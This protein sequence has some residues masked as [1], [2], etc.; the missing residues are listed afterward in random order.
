MIEI[1]LDFQKIKTDYDIYKLLY[2]KLFNIELPINLNNDKRVVWD[3]FRDDFHNILYKEWGEYNEVDWE[4]YEDYLKDKNQDS[5]YGIKNKQGVRDDMQLVF[6]NFRK[7]YIEYL[8][9]AYPF[10]EMIFE[11]IE[12]VNSDEWRVDG[13]M[14]Q[15]E[16]LIKS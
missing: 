4:N 2:Q 9:I 10:L 15:I 14:N 6:I 16:I 1:I 8:G 3:T 12:E 7:F 5:Q 13:M 11:K